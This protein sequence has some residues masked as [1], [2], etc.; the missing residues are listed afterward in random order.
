VNGL[1]ETEPEIVTFIIKMLEANRNN[2]VKLILL[3]FVLLFCTNLSAQN[4]ITLKGTVIDESNG[5]PIS[6]VTIFMG[7]S[8]R[9]ICADKNGQFNILTDSVTIKTKNAVFTSPQYQDTLIP[10]KE[11]DTIVK[12]LPYYSDQGMMCMNYINSLKAGVN[13]IRDIHPIKRLIIHPL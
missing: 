1:I 9:H 7:R 12:L 5:N 4:R 11:L 2:S 10:L 13:A 3:H 6:D 8:Y